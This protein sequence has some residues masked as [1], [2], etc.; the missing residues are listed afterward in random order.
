VRRPDP[1]IVVF[2]DYDG[3]ITDRDTLDVLVQRAAGDAAWDV[4]EAKLKRGEL[5]LRETLARQAS[6]VRCSLDDADAHLRAT[7]GFD[8]TFAAFVA[9][10]DARGIPV[11]VVSS[12]VAP[13][14]RR[15]LEHNGLGHLTLVANEVDA[16]PDGWRL[17]FRDPSANGTDKH[18]LVRAAQAGG[19]T[20]VYIGD[21]ISDYD[22]AK[23]A[24]RRFVKTGRSLHRHLS[25]L[26]LSFVAFTRFAEIDAATL[27]AA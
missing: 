8:P 6:L 10:C 22:A 12:G 9:A 26:G 5:S 18:G 4:L 23:A 14:I 20:V 11:S 15:R 7:V 21:G 19:K 13:L 2:V 25:Q 24:D 16:H 27:A 3:T 17:R 1:A